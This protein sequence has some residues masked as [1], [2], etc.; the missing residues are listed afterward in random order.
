MDPPPRRAGGESV[1]LGATGDAH[2]E[3]QLHRQQDARDVPTAG[4]VQK[5]GQGVRANNQLCRLDQGSR[6]YGLMY[7]NLEDP[8]GLSWELNLRLNKCIQDWPDSSHIAKQ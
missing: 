7:D 6:P 8:I 1:R 4:P 2:H 3:P 5:P